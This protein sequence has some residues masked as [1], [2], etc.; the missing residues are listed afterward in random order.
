[1][2][3][4]FNW[5][6]TLINKVA[7]FE[8]IISHKTLWDAATTSR[9]HCLVCSVGILCLCFSKTEAGHNIPLNGEYYRQV[10][11]DFSVLES[12][13][14]DMHDLRFQQIGATCHTA[15]KYI[16]FLK[17]TTAERM[18]SRRG[19]F[20][21]DRARLTSVGL[22][23][24]DCLH[25]LAVPKRLMPWKRTLTY[26]ANCCKAWSKSGSQGWNSRHSSHLSEIIF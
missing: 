19:H 21:Q 4:T 9:S 12:V 8:V 22:Y 13:E 2:K 25:S 26:I 10:I 14:V 11:N 17:A 6:S 24:V 7:A 20:L 3:F 1:M 23:E 15:K 18:I 16:N 5:M